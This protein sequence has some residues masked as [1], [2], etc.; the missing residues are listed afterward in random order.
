MLQRS[1]S[2]AS[3]AAAAVGAAQAR[4]RPSSGRN[5]AEV[6]CQNAECAAVLDVTAI[7]VEY[8]S[9]FGRARL[10]GG[11]LG[12]VLRGGRHARALGTT[13]HT[14]RAPLTVRARTPPPPRRRRYPLCSH[15][16]AAVSARRR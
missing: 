8:E 4:A 9:E 13:G 15:P 1:P 14:A 3:S 6:R 12:E 16:A 2:F 10:R 11:R 7:P 5:P